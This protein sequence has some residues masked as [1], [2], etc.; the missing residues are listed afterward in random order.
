[1]AIRACLLLKL[2]VPRNWQTDMV[3]YPGNYVAIPNKEQ[4]DYS[5]NMR[6]KLERGVETIFSNG[7][8]WKYA[9][10]PDTADLGDIAWLALKE[11]TEDNHSQYQKLKF[12]FRSWLYMLP[13]DRGYILNKFNT[14]FCERIENVKS[15]QRTLIFC[16]LF[17][18]E[19][20]IMFT[21]IDSLCN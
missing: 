18:G 4:A 15:F 5:M 21:D 16:R 17:I 13:H 20:A 9:D 2:Y 1:M 12:A 3:K 8:I 14:M 7:I 10:L 19:L 11:N 6:A